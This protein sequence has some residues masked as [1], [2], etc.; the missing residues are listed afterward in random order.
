MTH[1]NT[2]FTLI[3]AAGKKIA[4]SNNVI[5]VLYLQTRFV[6]I[7]LITFT[8]VLFHELNFFLDIF[9]QIL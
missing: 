2:V 1:T 5:Y 7:I 3:E 9:L 4:A 8:V 6:S